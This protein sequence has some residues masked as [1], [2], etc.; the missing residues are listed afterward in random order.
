LDTIVLI[1]TVSLQFESAAKIAFACGAASASF[2]FFSVLGYGAVKLSRIIKRPH[3]WRVLD[4][5]VA[6]VMFA[7]AF[8]M[9]RAGGWI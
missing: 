8:S 6:L 2:I 9:A 4:T 7:L 3:A 1:G 5:V